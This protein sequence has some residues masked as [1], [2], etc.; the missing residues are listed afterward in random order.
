MIGKHVR[1]HAYILFIHSFINLFNIS[2]ASPYAV[3]IALNVIP[4]MLF[5]LIVFSN[6]MFVIL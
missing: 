4:E 5:F 6:L 3:I 1:T 2:W